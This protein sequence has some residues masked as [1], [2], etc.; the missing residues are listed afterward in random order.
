MIL[1]SST[2]KTY[3]LVCYDLAWAAP[4]FLIELK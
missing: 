3:M 2:I 1:N 4:D